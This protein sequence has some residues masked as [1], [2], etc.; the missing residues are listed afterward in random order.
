MRRIINALKIVHFALSESKLD[1]S[2]R[3]DDKIV[4]LRLHCSN[5]L[6]DEEVQQ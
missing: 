1:V 6:S 5:H 4:T 3:R 2:W